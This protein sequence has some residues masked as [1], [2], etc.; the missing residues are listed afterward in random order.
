MIYIVIN[1]TDGAMIMKIVIIGAGSVGS[2]ICKQL[3]G[4]GHDL[5]VVDTDQALLTELSNVC[6][7]LENRFME[8]KPKEEESK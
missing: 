8:I 3:A 6:E 5:T 2:A 7:E 1:N 4:E